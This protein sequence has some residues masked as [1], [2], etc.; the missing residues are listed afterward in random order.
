VCGQPGHFAAKCSDRQ[1]A[2]KIVNMVIGETAAGT[3][4]YGNYLPQFFQ[5]VVHLSG[6]LIQELIFMC[7]VMFP[8]YL[9]IRSAGLPPC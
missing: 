2:R 4:G 8:C 9:L 3:S 7:V 1:G 6:G 5:F